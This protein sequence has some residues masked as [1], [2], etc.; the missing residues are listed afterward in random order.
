MPAV[1][2]LPATG[3]RCLLGANSKPGL[4]YSWSPAAGL[5]NP[6]I[7][8]PLASPLST[9][10]YILTTSHDG[11]G[12][13]NKDTVVVTASIIDTSLQLIGKDMYCADSGDSAILKGQSHHKYSMVQG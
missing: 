13:V 4:A 2:H 1:I 10:S 9:T 7:A 6:K 8:N 11:G 3:P 5:S 12:C